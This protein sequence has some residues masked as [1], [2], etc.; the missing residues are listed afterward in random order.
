MTFTV[1]F[2]RGK[3][4]QSDASGS[5]SRLSI[6]FGITRSMKTAISVEDSLMARADDAAR[7]LGLSRSALVS[8][9]LLNYLETRQNAKVTEDLNKAYAQV[10]TANERA[11]VRKLRTKVPIV[12]RW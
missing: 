1:M 10:P 8:E 5:L 6:T 9:A 12:D 3:V 7:E 4:V 11:L 2:C